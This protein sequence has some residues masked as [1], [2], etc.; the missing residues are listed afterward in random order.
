MFE[1]KVEM[2]QQLGVKVYVYVFLKAPEISEHRA[3]NEALNTIRY[4]IG[5]GVDEIALSCA[6]VSENTPLEHEYRNGSFTPPTLWSIAEIL[7]HAKENNWPLSLGGFDDTPPPIAI[8]SNCHNC[9]PAI[10][11]LFELYRKR[12]TFRISD[13]PICS[14]KKNWLA[15]KQLHLSLID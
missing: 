10:Y 3:L 1:K 8:P 13:L 11:E 12:G 4:L 14:C 15:D 9:N 2:L 7:H 5:L 6:F